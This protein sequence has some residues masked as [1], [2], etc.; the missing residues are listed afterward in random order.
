[1]FSMFN[2]DILFEIL[3][4]NK[5]VKCINK[6]F[7][8]QMLTRY[9][10]DKITI[11]ELSHY[12]VPFYGYVDYH[13]KFITYLA[14]YN[15]PN[16][17]YVYMYNLQSFPEC[18][19]PIYYNNNLKITSSSVISGDSEL[20][21]LMKK[22]RFYHP[23]I[24]SHRFQYKQELINFYESNT[25]DFELMYNK[26]RHLMYLSNY[27]IG[28]NNILSKEFKFRH[29]KLVDRQDEFNDYIKLL[30]EMINAYL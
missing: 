10:N 28:L 8:L 12:K 9:G 17:W 26:I 29:G 7:Y 24:L 18:V 25:T 13:Y 22:W 27:V 30:T 4:Y 2:Q 5:Y 1:M 11:N 15:K 19:S 21:Q 20:Q 6:Y 16:C 3:K 23:S 14:C